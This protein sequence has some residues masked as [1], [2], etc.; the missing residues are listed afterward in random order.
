MDRST[1]AQLRL[2]VADI[3][4]E[5]ILTGKI[6]IQVRFSD[7]YFKVAPNGLLEA[8]KGNVVDGS[9]GHAQIEVKSGADFITF[10]LAQRMMQKLKL[11]GA[12]YQVILGARNKREHFAVHMS[13]KALRLRLF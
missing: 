12:E 6:T 8:V 5:L 7:G 13:S 3:R 4:D 11:L 9:P 10:G 2:Q 1:A